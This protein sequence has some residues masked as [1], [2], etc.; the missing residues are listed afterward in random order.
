MRKRV[1]F[2]S[3]LMMAILGVW[4]QKFEQ[5]GTSLPTPNTYRTASGAPGKDY[6]QQRADYKIEL[7]LDDVKQEIEGTET[8][9]YFNQ[10]PDPL[11]YLWLQL[12]QNFRAQD[13]ET[14]L[15]T[16]YFMKDSVS[17]KELFTIQNN[18]DGGFRIDKVL[19]EI[20]RASCR[21]RV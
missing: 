20:G 13:S 14:P 12:D 2:L 17:S 1:F 5:L 15:V 11:D 19:D 9:T 8:I 4:G 3:S 7:T 6:W 21:E 18:F 10:S 16:E